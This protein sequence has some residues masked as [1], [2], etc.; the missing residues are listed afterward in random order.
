MATAVSELGPL[1]HVELPEGV[2]R[3]HA[4]G[5]GPPIVFVHGIIANADVWRGVVSRLRENYRCITPD[6]PLGGHTDPMRP[7]TDFTLFGLA[8][9]VQ[10]TIAA[11]DLTAPA[12]VG[13]DTGGAICQA[14]AAR[15][16]D[17]IASLVL[18]PCDAFDNFL[19]LPIRHLQLFGRTPAGLKVLAE[20]LRLRAIQ[21]LPIAFGLLTRRLIP[22]DIMA[23]YTA[24]LREHPGVRRDFAQ[25]VRA[26]SPAFTREA[27]EGLRTFPHPALIA[28]ARQNFFPLAHGERL[29]GLIP[30]A[31]LR[32]IEDSGPFVTEDQPDQTAALIAEF[33]REAA[34]H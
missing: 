29:A 34:V 16:S 25:L 24:P 18:T 10:R 2:I 8:D 32:V 13:N 3:Y 30:D 7:G 28:W 20:T 27:A 15:H 12:L 6:W 26:I 17:R 11:L 4:T 33:L 19:P 14:V 23:S 5:S 9:L 22:A 21:R 1:H 31:R